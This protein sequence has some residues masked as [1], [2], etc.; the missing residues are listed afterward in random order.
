MSSI[1]SVGKKG[2]GSAVF[3]MAGSF[4]RGGGGWGA[5]CFCLFM[6]SVSLKKENKKN[7]AKRKLVVRK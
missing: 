2:F 3:R 7:N 1:S 4:T 5:G 6:V